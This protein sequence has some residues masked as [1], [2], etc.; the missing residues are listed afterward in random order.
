MARQQMNLNLFSMIFSLVSQWTPFLAPQSPVGSFQQYQ[1][2]LILAQGAKF[3]IYHGPIANT[4]FRTWE[5]YVSKSQLINYS[6]SLAISF[7]SSLENLSSFFDNLRDYKMLL[8]TILKIL[9]T[10]SELIHIS[11]CS[12]LLVILELIPICD[13]DSGEWLS[14]P[15]LCLFRYIFDRIGD[16]PVLKE[17]GMN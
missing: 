17:Y 14:C 12:K 15:R 16:E 6:N 5:W 1:C 11:T 3:Q 13:V 2:R 7:V 4:L 8:D 10:K 9:E